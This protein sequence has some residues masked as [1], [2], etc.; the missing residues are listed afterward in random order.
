MWR[1]RRIGLLRNAVIVVANG[2]HIEALPAVCGLLRDESE[3][4]YEYPDTSRRVDTPS[5]LDPDAL[6][7]SFL[8]L[9]KLL[10]QQPLAWM[11]TASAALHD[12]RERLPELLTRSHLMRPRKL[13]P[14]V[15]ELFM[16]CHGAPGAGA[17]T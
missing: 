16:R 7:N 1:P 12:F 4:G 13:R 15:R 8:D 10:V 14:E 3:V 6:N 17:Q 9:K 11:G 2:E 5:D